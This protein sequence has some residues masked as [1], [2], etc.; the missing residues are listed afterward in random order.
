MAELLEAEIRLRRVKEDIATDLELRKAQMRLIE[1]EILDELQLDIQL[2]KARV[3]EASERSIEEMMREFD[4]VEREMQGVLKELQEEKE[5]M[6]K[7]LDR[8]ATS[9]NQTLF[10]QRL[11]PTRETELSIE[12]KETARLL[13]KRIKQDSLGP[14]SEMSSGFRSLVHA[15][16]FAVPTLLVTHDLLTSNPPAYAK[17]AALAAVAACIAL[18]IW[19]EGRKQREGEW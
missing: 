18:N 19:G 6:D 12:D 8:A 14:G 1:S 16:I 13:A 9:Q 15:F 10:F 7:F 4:E 2:D 17:D 3:E 11:Y 5:E